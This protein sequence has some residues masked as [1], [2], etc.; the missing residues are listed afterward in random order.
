MLRQLGVFIY[1]SLQYGTE[2][3]PFRDLEDFI[4]KGVD[5]DDAEGKPNVTLHKIVIP[6][7]AAPEIFERLELMGIDGTRLY[8]NHEGAVADVKN[9]YVFNRKT[10]YAHDIITRKE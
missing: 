4:E 1:D 9:S 6:N 8:D 2:P 3:L 7:G 10:G 5:P